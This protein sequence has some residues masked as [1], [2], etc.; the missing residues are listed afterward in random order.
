[1]IIGDI[2]SIFNH[3][4]L[5]LNNKGIRM[6]NAEE[7]CA[8][9]SINSDDPV[10]FSTFVENE[11]AYIYYALLN[12]GCKREEAL[13]WIDK[14]RNQGI[15]SSFIKHSKNSNEMIKDFYEILHF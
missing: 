12:A 3:P 15:E 13:T 1:M 7:T 6:K 2:P 9:V 5:R 10:V 8:L 4:I 11:I 14:I